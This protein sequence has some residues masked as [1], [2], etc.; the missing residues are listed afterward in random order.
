MLYHRVG[1]ANFITLL[2]QKIGSDIKPYTSMLLKLLFPVI[3][4]ERSATCKRAF[5]GACAIVLKY[6]AGS[7]AQT[8]IEETAA[9]HTGDRNDQI[10]CAVLLKSYSSLA[11]DVLSGY[12]ATIIPVIFLSRSESYNCFL[13]LIVKE[14]CGYSC[15]FIYIYAL[16]L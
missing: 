15:K 2:V 11:S 1:T 14:A 5:A 8:L 12:H 6:S 4:V 9:L 13:F 3:K 16:I 7:L 10:T